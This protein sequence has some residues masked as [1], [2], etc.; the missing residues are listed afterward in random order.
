MRSSQRAF[1]AGPWIAGANQSIGALMHGIEAGFDSTSRRFEGFGTGVGFHP[2]G[3]PDDHGAAPE[4]LSKARSIPRSKSNRRAVTTAAG[5][6]GRPDNFASVTMPSPATRAVLGTSAVKATSFPARS[7]RAMARNATWPPRWS[8]FSPLPPDPR[9]LSTPSRRRTTALISA[10]PW[11][12]IKALAG[13]PG[14]V[15]KG[16]IKCWPCHIATIGGHS[17]SNVATISGGSRMK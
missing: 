12:E 5:N 8:I 15:P 6:I 7:A 14:G 4:R 2:Y 9:M 11:R 17:R 10:S 13:R 16:T 3:F 1:H